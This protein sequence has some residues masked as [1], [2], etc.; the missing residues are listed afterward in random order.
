[1]NLET[2][3]GSKV[4]CARVRFPAPKMHQPVG[5]F[6]YEARARKTRKSRRSPEG[7]L[8]E[9][10]CSARAPGGRYLLYIN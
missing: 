1:M 2:A 7:R 8:Y 9:F 3:D 4:D 10:A 5:T 6:K